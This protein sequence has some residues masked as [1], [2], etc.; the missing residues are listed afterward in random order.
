MPARLTT[1]ALIAALALATAG[2]GI[3]ATAIICILALVWELYV[4]GKVST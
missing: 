1:A 2:A 4:T 3:V